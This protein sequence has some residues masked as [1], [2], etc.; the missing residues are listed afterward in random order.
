M[1]SV[2]VRADVTVRM[3]RCRCCMR[4]H[5][6]VLMAAESMRRIKSLER[7]AGWQLRTRW[8]QLPGGGVDLICWF[9]QLDAER[10][11]ESI[12]CAGGPA[13]WRALVLWQRRFFGITEPVTPWPPPPREGALTA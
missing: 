13:A 11:V 5:E 8:R 9:C 12:V 2:T 4:T 7:L 10:Y 6:Q 1:T 3:P